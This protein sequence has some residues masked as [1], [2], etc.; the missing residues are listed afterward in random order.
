MGSGANAGSRSFRL[1]SDVFDWGDFGI[2]VSNSQAGTTY[3]NALLINRT[4]AATFSSSVTATNLLTTSMSG[5]AINIRGDETL[6]S[7]FGITWTTPT[8]T[9]GIAAIRVARRGASDASDMMF[10]TSPNGDIPN[11]RMR[12]TS[13]GNV[14][15]GVTDTQSFRL[16][17]DGPNVTQGDANTTIRIFDTTSATTGTGGGISFGGYFDGT[18]SVA[19]TLSYIKGAKENSTAGNF[20]SYLSFGTRINDGNPSER[21]RITSIGE[22]AFRG[23]TTSANEALFTND[24]S[25]LKIFGGNSGSSTK[26]IAF[27]VS[28]GSTTPE[29]LRITSG[30]NVG[31]GTTSPLTRLTVNNGGAS[32]TTNYQFKN[33]SIMSGFIGGYASSAIQSLIAGYDST[34]YYGT[35][36]GY[37]YD[38]TG[39]GLTFSTNATLNSNPPVERMRITSGGNV[40]IGTASPG[41]SLEIYKEGSATAQLK[42]GDASTAKGYLGVFSNAVYINAGGTFNGGWSTDGSNGIAGIVL[43]TSNGGSAIAFGTTASNTSPSERMRIVAGGNVGIGTTTPAF[44]LD[45]NGEGKVTGKFRVGGAVMLAEPGTGVLLFGSEGGSQTAIYSASAERIRIDTAGNV[46]IGTTDPL[47]I[48]HTTGISPSSGSSGIIERIRN[49]YYIGFASR[50]ISSDTNIF[51]VSGFTPVNSSGGAAVVRVVISG[52]KVGIDTFASIYEF[53]ILRNAQSALSVTEQRNIGRGGLSATVSGNEVIFA[54]LFASYSD[55]IINV[56]LMCINGAPN[57]EQTVSLLFL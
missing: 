12:I 21:M 33:L 18:T 19:N 4:G 37:F 11:E 26:G 41:R 14:G 23:S 9:G 20:A 15:I 30:G 31:I 27:H 24:S 55:A 17:V 48:L 38:G 42:I 13:G 54:L 25:L 3:T 51:K 57:F 1:A 2:Q 28:N 29:V 22:I 6:N 43:E 39:Y 45:V 36:I 50:I 32:T 16:A 10:F 46:G 34:T 8:Y 49:N 44:K 53:T 56:E 40:G 7:N 47:A 52:V 5:G 35:D